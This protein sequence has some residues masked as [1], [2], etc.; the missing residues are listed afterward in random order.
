M[1]KRNKYILGIL[2]LAIILMG[3][4]ARVYNNL[5][6]G[7]ERVNASWS[8]VSNQYER[9]AELIPNL[10]NTVKGYAA[11]EQET[12]TKVVEARAKATQMQLE[13]G[14]LNPEGLQQYLSAQEELTQALSKLMVTVEAYPDLKA[15]DAFLMLQTQ[16]EGTENRI[17]VERRR[18]I[19]QVKGY[20]SYIRRFPTNIVAKALGFRSK[21]Y[22]EASEGAENGVEVKF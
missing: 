9:R 21:D 12:L 11:H 20:N 3:Y 6:S 8:Q 2:L 22:F 19:E 15:S 10:V 5:V 1:K 14:E 18:F 7:E 4:G 17:A 16:L 13:P